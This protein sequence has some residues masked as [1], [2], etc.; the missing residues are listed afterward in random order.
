MFKFLLKFIYLVNIF[1]LLSIQIVFGEI[2][3]DIK[4]FGNERISSETIKTFSSINI[5]D[6]ID[7]TIINE[8]LK[9]LYNSN[10]FATP[11][12]DYFGGYFRP[13]K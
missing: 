9:S 2:V 10:F 6:D 8:S 13:S 12:L 1:Y 5:N 11:M 7:D 4:I 3:K